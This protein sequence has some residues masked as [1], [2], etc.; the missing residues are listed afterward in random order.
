MVQEIAGVP[1]GRDLV[2]RGAADAPCCAVG[3]GVADGAA[4]DFGP[5]QGQ[6][7]LA[8][9]EHCELTPS[10]VN[11]TRQQPVIGAHAVQ[12]RLA[13]LVQAVDSNVPGPHALVQVAQVSGVPATR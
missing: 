8:Q 9:L 12:T 7:P 3:H 10:C 6:R 13:L 5:D 11:G 1:P 4:V 2:V